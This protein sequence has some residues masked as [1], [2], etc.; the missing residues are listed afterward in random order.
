MFVQDLVLY[1]YKGYWELS[2][3]KNIWLINIMR[4]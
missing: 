1:I 2:N 3:A 4:K